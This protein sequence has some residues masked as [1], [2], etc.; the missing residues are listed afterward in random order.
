[1]SGP[2]DELGRLLASALS[3]AERAALADCAPD[4]EVEAPDLGAA[5]G[6]AEVAAW[7]ARARAIS[8]AFFSLL[9]WW[10]PDRVGAVEALDARFRAHPDWGEG[11]EPWPDRALAELAGITAFSEGLTCAVSGAGRRV[12]ISRGGGAVEIFGVASYTTSRVIFGAELLVGEGERVERGAP[13]ARWDRWSLPVLARSAGGRVSL[14][15]VRE[16]V[17]A[18]RRDGALYVRRGPDPTLRPRV[19]VRG[20]LERAHHLPAGA[21]IVA[22]EGA[23]TVAGDTLAL[24]PSGGWW[25]GPGDEGL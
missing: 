22:A 12:V 6:G 15:D 14:V 24:L 5:P 25:P 11:A 8:G 2:V 21:R 13:L 18:W 3:P 19:V 1:M 23:A 7:L 4:V 16:G 17:N 20:A 9:R 10:L